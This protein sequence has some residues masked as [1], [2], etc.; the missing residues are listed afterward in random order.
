MNIKL[1]LSRMMD[2]ISLIGFTPRCPIIQVVGTNGKGSTVAF[3]EAILKSHHLSTGL[4]TSPHLSC[5]RERIRIN[6]VMITENDF[7]DA[8]SLVLAKADT[9]KDAP[10]FFE[11]ILAMALWV[12]NKYDVAYIIL[13]AGIGGRLDAT[14]AAKADILGITSID[15][16]HQHILGDSI[17]KIAQEK[18]A[19]ARAKQ[20]VIYAKQHL[21]V[22]NIIH[23][24]AVSLGFHAYKAD[25]LT[26][27]LGLYGEHQ[28]DNAGLALAILHHLNVSLNDKNIEQ[29]LLNVNWPGRFE[30]L[31][32][33]NR[34]I[35]L[36]GA[37]NPSGITTFI[38]SFKTHPQCKDKPLILVYGSLAGDNAYE[39][40]ELLALSNLN[41]KQLF[42][43][44]SK[45]PR[46]LAYDDMVSLYKKA[47]FLPA[48]ITKF[49]DWYEVEKT[50]QNNDAIIAICGSLYTIGEIRSLL[51]SCPMDEKPSYF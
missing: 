6:G 51:L 24:N 2:L 42:L 32:K 12:F 19:A 50:A 39:K 36:D 49:Y 22:E 41:I 37:H 44:T 20:K 46:S 23:H 4:F 1:G 35:V 14:T 38:N 3:I 45:N 17:E 15:L 43:Y 40:I 29:G 16:D 47:K 28:Q 10:S 34:L 25:A 31:T 48:K 18:L 26:K 7:I 9:M 33:N 13:E 21:S 30:I 5:A 8:A 11:C 27:P